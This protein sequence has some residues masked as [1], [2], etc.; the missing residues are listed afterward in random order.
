MGSSIAHCDFIKNMCSE[1]LNDLKVPY[2]ATL[3]LED[4]FK[5]DDKSLDINNVKQQ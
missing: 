4:S 2:D 5:V 1:L 3:A